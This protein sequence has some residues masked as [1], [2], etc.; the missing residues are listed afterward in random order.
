MKKTLIAIVGIVMLAVV[1][2]PSAQAGNQ[3]S[4]HFGFKSDALTPKARA[5][6]ESLALDIKHLSNVVVTSYVPAVGD[7]ALNQEFATKRVAA[8]KGFLISQGVSDSIISTQTIP[9]SIGKS[10]MVELSYGTGAVP[11]APMSAPA[12]TPPP[13]PAPM[14]DLSAAPPPPAKEPVITAQPKTYE[15]GITEEDVASGKPTKTPSRWE[16]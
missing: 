1:A 6:L 7:V 16:H 12:A 2:V 15:S 3:D 11:S 9:G 14:D 4:V 8:V 13:P 5:K 10:R